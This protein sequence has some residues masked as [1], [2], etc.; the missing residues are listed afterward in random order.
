MIGDLHCHTRFSDGSMGID[1]LIF[2]AKRAGLDFIA[3]TDH[4]T[5]D[6]VTRAE[7]LGRRY[8]INVIPAVEISCKDMLRDRKV[9]ILCYLPEKP[10][11]LQGLFGQV[12][13]SRTKTG[14]RIIRAVMRYYPVTEEHIARYTLGSKSIYKAHII[15]ALLDLG[16]DCQSH[17]DLYNDIFS[18]NGGICA[19]ECE[20]P[21]VFDAIETIRSAGGIAVLA[22]PPIYETMELMCELAQKQLIQG[23]EAFHPGI[24][25]E[26]RA[27]ICE[28]A[29]KYG[30]IKTGGS[31]FHGFLTSR[32]NP[33]ATCI[34]IENS[35]NAMYQLKKS[36]SKKQGGTL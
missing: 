29:D 33:L 24:G 30:L 16:Y 23:V 6:G 8:G 31:D 26:E 9:H 11:R 25:A 4:D 21:D 36:A 28:L 2:Y 19:R 1:D 20:Y 14:K 12:L 15:Q 3:V 10:D 27:E 17:G 34:T 35:I 7:V 22:H 32:P 13:D 18:S 5:M